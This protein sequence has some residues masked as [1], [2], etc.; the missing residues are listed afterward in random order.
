MQEDIEKRFGKDIDVDIE[1]EY[2]VSYTE[3]I[4][5]NTH[6]IQKTMKRTYQSQTRKSR[7]RSSITSNRSKTWALRTDKQLNKT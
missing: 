6:M 3:F 7:P 4:A 1:T 5:L 2:G